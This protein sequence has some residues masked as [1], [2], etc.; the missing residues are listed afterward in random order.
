MG[1]GAA[2]RKRAVGRTPSRAGYYLKLLRELRGF[3][4][5]ASVHT[6]SGEVTHLS[7]VESGEVPLTFD[8]VKRI[9]AGGEANG[10]V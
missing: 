1:S 8:Y 4:Q 9:A 3:K 10:L 2:V 6:Y 7:Q 5:L